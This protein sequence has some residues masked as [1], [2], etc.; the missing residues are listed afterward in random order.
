M[1]VR[2]RVN[3]FPPASCPFPPQVARWLGAGELRNDNKKS[4][5][6]ADDTLCVQLVEFHAHKILLLVSFLLSRVVYLLTAGHGA[7]PLTTAVNLLRQVA[8]HLQTLGEEKKKAGGVAGFFGVGGSASTYSVQFRLAARIMAAFIR[9]QTSRSPPTVRCRSA[10]E[11]V[12]SSGGKKAAAA[13]QALVKNKTYAEL[14]EDVEWGS[15]FVTDRHRSLAD[16]GEL[17]EQIATRL[18]PREAWLRNAVRVMAQLE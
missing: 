15:R 10:E 6:G 17:L 4:A 5:Y 13:L 11:P 1:R 16:F 2:V 18:F 7:L 9:G 14:V 3:A 8:N 12:A